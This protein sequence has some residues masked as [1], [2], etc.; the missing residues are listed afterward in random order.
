MTHEKDHHQ[1]LVE[2]PPLAKENQRQE[3]GFPLQHQISDLRGNKNNHRG[4][5]P[6]CL[7]VTK[8]L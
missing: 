5:S 1:S 8:F 3:G 4:T 7:N 2:Q 6:E